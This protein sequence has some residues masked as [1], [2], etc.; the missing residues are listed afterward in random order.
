MISGLLGLR[1]SRVSSQLHPNKVG[2]IGIIQNFLLNFCFKD[3]V[4]KVEFYKTVWNPPFPFS[5]MLDICQSLLLLF[6][7]NESHV[8]DL[9]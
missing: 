9:Q 1:G 6:G 2:T 3:S 5:P 7:L 4:G 8:S